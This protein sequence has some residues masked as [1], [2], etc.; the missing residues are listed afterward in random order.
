MLRFFVVIACSYAMALCPLAMAQSMLRRVPIAAAAAAASIG[1]VDVYMDC[2]T[3][4]AGTA[5]TT[6][7]LNNCTQG[8]TANAGTWSLSSSHGMT[9]EA[10][11]TDC[12]MQ[13]DVSVLG[14]N[15][16]TS[17][18][19]KS[20]RFDHAK[21][22]KTMEL[23]FP[24]RFFTMT[25]AGCLISG[26]AS[27][28]PGSEA[29]Y[30]FVSIFGAATGSFAVMQLNNGDCGGGGTYAL[31]IETNPGGVTTHSSC[32]TISRNTAYW[33]SLT[34]DFLSGTASLYIYTSSG[35]LV[36]S[37]TST[38][39]TAD[40]IGWVR[41]G[42]NQTGSSSG[43]YSYF[44][45]TTFSY[46]GQAPVPVGPSTFNGPPIYHIQTV[47][48]SGNTGATT[49]ASAAMNLQ[50]GNTVVVFVSTE[51]AGSTVSSIADTAGNTYTSDAACKVTLASNGRG[52]M[53]YAK[54]TTANASNV[55]TATFSGSSTYRRIFASQIGGASTSAPFDVCG[56]G[57]T[58]SGSAD[59]TTGSFTPTGTVL[60]G[61]YNKGGV[62]YEPNTNY[63]QIYGDN[64]L[65]ANMLMR[66]SAPSS[67]QT[68]TAKTT[69][70]AAKWAVA[71]A[72]KQ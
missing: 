62:T 71:M 50:A 36:G 69:N 38:M 48:G 55:V 13:A 60:L 6:T 17:S 64:T 3:S 51:T 66:G 4:S 45:N 57:T 43:N 54:N 33:Y 28:S 5:L 9:I 67:S 23:T 58:S 10:H 7:I 24:S 15:F 52:E 37:T 70:T 47:T 72:L 2:N 59:V 25:V 26:V 65:S 32:I 19:T 12:A 49:I 11:Q 20:I 68:A 34:A 16:P 30:D 29:L 61:A 40:F 35:T 22:Q 1:P 31:N 41:I 21:T 42:Q 8:R 63:V 44:E 18:S 53:W 46:K 39:Q 56:T 27:V 14:T